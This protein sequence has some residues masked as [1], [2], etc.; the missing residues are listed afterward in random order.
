MY[1]SGL[2]KN[3]KVL[4]TGGRSGIGY[5]I[6][7]AFLTYGAEVMI[8]SRK[9]EPLQAAANELRTFGTCHAQICDIREPEAIEKLGDVIQE[10]MGGLDILINNAGG[11]FPAPSNVI[12]QNGWCY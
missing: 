1:A 6:A 11:Q 8:A 10:T 4:V 3:K 7:K 12:A 5:G 9:Q 2:F